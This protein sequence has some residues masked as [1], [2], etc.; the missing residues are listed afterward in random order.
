MTNK[1]K[2]LFGFSSLLLILYLIFMCNGKNIN[3]YSLMGIPAYMNVPVLSKEELTEK[4][5]GK[6]QIF[7]EEGLYYNYA[8]APM[9]IDRQTVYIYQNPEEDSWEGSFSLDEV[10]RSKEY[11]SYFLEDTFFDDKKEAIKQGH[12]FSLYIIGEDYYKMDVVF[13][14]LGII[15]ITK[16]YELP[17]E[18][19]DYFDDPDA[20]VF[21]KQIESVGEVTVLSA[22]SDASYQTVQGYVKYRLKGATSIN[23]PK[24]GYAITFIDE[25]GRD[26]SIPVFGM[27]G[28]PKW[29]L[30]A[31][32]LDDTLV[33]EKSA[34]DIWNLIDDE[35]QKVDNGSFQA[36][37][38]EFICEGSYLGVYLLVEAVDEDKLALDNNDILYKSISTAIITPETIDECASYGWKVAEPY[39]IRYPKE[40]IDYSKVWAPIREYM[41][42]FFWK[43]DTGDRMLQQRVHLDNLID[44]NILLETCVLRDNNYK[45]LYIAAHMNE[46]GTYVM[47]HHPWDMDMS[48][49]YNMG[50]TAVEIRE[51]VSSK[52]TMPVYDAIVK[53]DPRVAELFSE[54]YTK[55]RTSFLDNESITNIIEANWD[56]LMNS[57][58][59]KRNYEVWDKTPVDTADHVLHFV[60]DRLKYLDSIY[61]QK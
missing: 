22:G 52:Q 3:L 55:Y 33:R 7:L 32:W 2:G 31:L 49:D 24:K 13:S 15:N 26:V 53:E 59:Y 42:V 10:L 23:F 19:I 40:I 20:F 43:G 9:D 28:Y 35:N 21:D 34:I 61:L 14:G 48:F 5:S 39:R 6:E 11:K 36:K 37:Y 12:T 47:T 1:R 18:E 17:K 44:I 57:G 56:L 50:N 30:N 27:D 4:I 41:N 29:K 51:R 54:T 60:S 16:Q 8:K 25:N 38:V 45:N 58:A 46:D